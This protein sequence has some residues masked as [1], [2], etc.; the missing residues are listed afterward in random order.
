MSDQLTRRDLLLSA[1]VSVAIFSGGGAGAETAA[2]TGTTGR[3]SSVRQGS[4]T[5]RASGADVFGEWAQPGYDHQFTRYTP[6]SGPVGDQQVRWR[7]PV[8]DLVS[9]PLV[10]DDRVIVMERDDSAGIVHGYDKHTGEWLWDFATST[11]ASRFSLLTSDGKGYITETYNSR[12][13]AFSLDDGSEVWTSNFDVTAG[14]GLVGPHA[15]RDGELFLDHR[16]GPTVVIDA[17]SGDVDRTLPGGQGHAVGEERL[18]LIRGGDHSEEKLVAVDA[19]DGTELYEYSTQGRPREP[20]VGDQTV[21]VGTREQR[22]HAVDI[23]S[24]E[25]EWMVRLTDRPLAICLADD[26]L[27]VSTED[28]IFGLELTD[29]E[30]RWRID[31]GS[32]RPVVADDTLYVGESSGVAAYETATGEERFEWR[33]RDELPGNVARIAVVNNGI[34]ARTNHFEGDAVALLEELP[35]APSAGFSYAPSDP[36][37]TDEVTFDASETQPGDGAVTTYEWRFGAGEEFTDTGETVTRS[38]D[39]PGAVEVTLRVTDD[40][41]RTDTETATL[42]IEE[43]DPAS[44]AVTFEDV[45][46]TVVAGDTLTVDVAV[47]NTG[48]LADE[49]TLELTSDGETVADETVSLE[50]GAATTRSFDVD[51]SADASGTVD[52]TVAMADDDASTSVDIDQPTAFDVTI[53]DAP[54]QV[55]PA[56][57]FTLTVDVSNHGDVPGDGTVRVI[58]AGETVAEA[59]RTLDGG[60]AATLEFELGAP[61]SGGTDVEYTVT[62]DTD[63]ATVDV[64]IAESGAFSVALAESPDTVEPGELIAVTFEVRNVGDVSTAETLSFVVDG[65]VAAE[66]DLQLDGGETTTLTFDVDAPQV[67]TTLDLEGRTATEVA[68]TTVEVLAPAAVG[69]ELESVPD[70]ATVGSAFD[71]GVTLTN[72]GDVT[73]ES[74][75]QVAVGGSVVAE[76]TVE[77]D[78]GAEASP[79][80]DDVYTVSDGDT[81][82]VSVTAETG[83]ASDTAAVEVTQDATDDAGEDVTGD[84]GGETGTDDADG[85]DDADDESGAGSGDDGGVSTDDEIPGFGVGSAVAAVGGV[86]YALR[87]RLGDGDSQSDSE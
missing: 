8:G 81:P 2:R 56:E 20:T 15:V 30:E 23:D 27:V 18:F 50:G 34:F 31:S 48:Q 17:D 5:D 86:A 78:G 36:D 44:F 83:D 65:T 64:S 68:E 29:G 69:V 32:S 45:P 28:D 24:G 73:T 1:G 42:G 39:E 10:H 71:I 33:D 57:S 61:D 4:Q 84:D 3:Q 67:D 25:R 41:D 77:L 53:V 21:Y 70:E 54:E 37:T 79:T 72:Q 62:T 38:F 60:D 49:Q 63:E 74:H 43:P 9:P 59:E 52:L 66:E 82:E 16:A 6:A 12:V 26:V 51:T 11:T 40:N 87:Q 80:F 19:D 7:D 47:E 46:S 75:L 55:E 22:V 13:Y 14:D 76:E 58:Q 35:G 85:G